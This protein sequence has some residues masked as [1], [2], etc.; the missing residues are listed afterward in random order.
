MSDNPAFEG[1]NVLDFSRLIAGPLLTEYL[2]AHGATVAR[3]ESQSAP[4]FLRSSHPYKDA[5]PGINRS[6]YFAAFNANKYSIAL[7][8]SHPRAGEIVKRM[9]AWSDV[10][11]ENFTPGR[12]TKWGWSYQDLSKIKPD[13]IMLSTSNRGG[14]GPRAAEPG[15]GYSLVGLSGFTTMTGWPDREPCQPFG[16]ITDFVAPYLGA[17][18]LIAALDH[19]QR[20]GK[21]QYID[22]SQYECGLYTMSPLLMNYLVNGVE[23]ARL[24]NRSPYYAPQGAYPCRGEDSWCVISVEN[25]GQWS[26]LCRIINKPE[27]VDDPSFSSLELRKKNEDDLDRVLTQWTRKRAARKVMEILQAAGIPCGMVQNPA[28]I[29]D[30]VQLAYRNFFQT[31]EHPEIGPHKYQMPPFRLSSTP[32]RLNKPA[33]CFQQDSEYFYTK[34]LGLSDREFVEYLKE[35]ALS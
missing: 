7:N 30:D 18:A 29:L 22:I 32:A 4:C 17:I 28:D 10:V 34:V 20:T 9:V 25:D 21:G 15:L 26:S 12:M 31:L 8:L 1:L 3:I 23:P 6:G 13:L 27:L 35:G 14:T 11:V 2:A 33:P 5:K 16:A 19:H 24:G